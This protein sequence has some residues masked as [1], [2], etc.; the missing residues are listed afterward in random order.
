M[1]QDIFT[2]SAPGR[3]VYVPSGQYW[4]YV[5]NPLPPE[6]QW[7]SELIRLLSDADRQLGELAGLARLLPNPH[8]LITP[9]VRRE[10]VLSSQIEGTQASLSDLYAFEAMQLPLFDQSGD[11][12]EV[13]NYVQA[14]DHGL[15]RLETLPLSLRLLREVHEQL[16]SGV[17]GEFQTPGQFRKSQNWIGHPGCTLNEA[18]YVP[19]PVPEMWEALGKFEEFL[20]AESMLPPLVR[21]GLIHYQFEA[22]HP[23]LDGNGRIGRLLITMLLCAWNLLPQ[24]LLYLSAYFE[25]HRQTYYDLLFR[26]S[27][28]GVWADWLRFFLEGV[29]EQARDAVVRAQR[30]QDL[31]ENLRAHY[32]TN[33][34]PAGLLQLIDLLF[35]RPVVTVAQAVDYLNTSTPTAWRY[36]KRL[37]KDQVLRKVSRGERGRVFLAEGIL[38]AIEGQLP[39]HQEG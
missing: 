37:E 30:L 31:R 9:F 8:L 26:V 18:A 7:T 20:H 36:I 34:A 10:A 15:T 13:Y 38:A 3:V 24:P 6:I 33:D 27:S 5:P 23:F 1:K 16:M 11:V 39:N 19:P 4:G 35:A 29:K 14:L 21:L 28:E 25:T 12:K 17:R 2:S 32:Q 22:I